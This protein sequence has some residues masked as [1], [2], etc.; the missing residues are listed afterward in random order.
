MSLIVLAEDDSDDQ[1]M[2]REIIEG[3]DPAVELKIFDD[4]ERLLG[5]MQSINEQT[6]LPRL[7]ILDQNMPRLKGTETIQ[8]LKKIRGFESI[9]AVIYTTYHDS[10][11]EEDCKK[12]NVELFR[13]P[14]TFAEFTKMI[15][16]LMNRYV[17]G[18]K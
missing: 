14:D 18:S 5:S 2:V 17:D 16:G 10:K 15:G 4:G 11:F 1:D 6:Q 13:K 3:L 7:I 9:P 12:L 8:H